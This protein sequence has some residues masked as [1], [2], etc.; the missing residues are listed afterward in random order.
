M[1][2]FTARVA[3]E[4]V[5]PI[6][7]RN[8]SRISSGHSTTSSGYTLVSMTN[9][10]DG[11]TRNRTMKAEFRL[12]MLFAVMHAPHAELRDAIQPTQTEITANR[13]SERSTTAFQ[14]LR[15]SHLV[16]RISQSNAT[17]ALIVTVRETCR[18]ANQLAKRMDTSANS[19]SHVNR[20]LLLKSV[21]KGMRLYRISARSHTSGVTGDW[22]LRSGTGVASYRRSAQAKP[23]FTHCPIVH[24]SL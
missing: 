23:T 15:K 16:W 17:M 20:N 24:E 7:S 14:V 18:D 9:R 21:S 22:V 3:P 4:S 1:H 2:S 6:V 8:S 12:L 5:L 19:F 10:P 13:P 11:C